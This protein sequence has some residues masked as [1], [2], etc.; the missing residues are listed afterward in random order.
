MRSSGW[1][2]RF[3]SLE[4]LWIEDLAQKHANGTSV[5]KIIW[6]GG[7]GLV[8]GTIAFARGETGY[9]EKP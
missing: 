9:Q 8:C 1:L 7:S 3:K 5:Y 2:W 4:E 6:R